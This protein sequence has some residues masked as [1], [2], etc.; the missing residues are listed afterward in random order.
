MTGCVLALDVGGTAMKGAVLDRELTMRESRTFPTPVADG[1]HAVVAAIGDALAVLAGL[2]DAAGDL[3]PVRAAGV[4]VPG[5][6]DE[7]KGVAVFASNIGWRDVRLVDILSA[8]LGVPVALGHDIRIGLL[9]ESVVGAGRGMDNLLF[10]ALGTGIGGAVMTDGRVIAAG[11]Y[12]A[13]IGHVQVDP[14]GDQCGCGGI[15][16]LERIASA[17]AI[18]RAYTARSGRPAE[19]AAEVAAAVRVGDPD[20]AAVWDRAVAALASVLVTTTTLFGS[21]LILVG[22]GLSEAGDLLMLPL[23]GAVTARLTFQRPVRI[24][25]PGLGDRAGCVGAG[26]LA[27]RLVPGE[28]S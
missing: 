11:G 10:L 19:G 1:P 24:E 13:E 3:G 27:W 7:A 22:G 15:G 20:A 4:A 6:V 28:R 12:A 21:E 8:R 25:R 14:D 17:A 18:A 2:A 5:V 16:C 23:R 26:V 9:A